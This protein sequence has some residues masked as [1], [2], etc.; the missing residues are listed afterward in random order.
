MFREENDQDREERGMGAGQVTQLETQF[1]NG[2][3]GLRVGVS[4]SVLLLRVTNVST[5]GN[6]VCLHHTT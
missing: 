2:K 1:P 5:S 6:T 3:Q 4:F